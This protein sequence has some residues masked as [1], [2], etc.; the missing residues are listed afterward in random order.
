MIFTRSKVK[1]K[2]ADRDVSNVTTPTD[3]LISLL[4]STPSSAGEYI[5]P[6][7]A[8]KNA[9]IYSCIKIISSHIAMLPIQTFYIDKKGQRIRDKRHAVS[10]LIESRPNPY[11]TPFEFKQVMEAHRQLYGNA[12]AEIVWGADGYP[13]ALYP[14]NSKNTR[15]EKDSNGKLWVTTSVPTYGNFKIDYSN[16]IHLKSMNLNGLVGMSPIEVVKEQIG[17]QQA[18]QKFLGK[19]YANGTMSRGILKIPQQLNKEAKEKVRAEWESYGTGLSN[20]H[21]VAI[22]DAGL[23]YQSLGMSQTD[24]QFIE[25]QKYT[26]SEIAQI[27]NVPLHMLADLERATFSNIEQQSLEFVRDTLT[28]LLVSWEQ[29]LSY[30]LFSTNDI[31]RGYYIKFNLNTILRGDSTSRANYYEKMIQLGVYSI[32]E[33]RNLEELDGIEGG[34]DHRVDLNHISLK[35][36]DEYQMTKAGAKSSGPAPAPAE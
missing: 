15:L 30:Q 21:R 4:N 33:V 8:L 9:T 14:L 13:S 32:N 20:A 31:K 25:T 7:T 35:I 11:M 1:E 10:N 3:W 19:F 16:I 18:S 6:D 17:V 36:A 12:Y 2:R 24:A 29:T 23:D 22:L 34:D 28:P 27:Y 26:K 5:T